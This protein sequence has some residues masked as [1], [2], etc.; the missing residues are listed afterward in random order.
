MHLSSTRMKSHIPSIDVCREQVYKLCYCVGKVNHTDSC[1]LDKLLLN[2]FF[3]QI[4]QSLCLSTKENQDSLHLASTVVTRYYNL[5]YNYGFRF[6]YGAMTRKI[7]SQCPPKWQP[8][9][10]HVKIVVSSIAMHMRHVWCMHWLLRKKTAL[11]TSTSCDSCVPCIESTTL[12][13]LII[14]TH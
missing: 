6:F 8:E 7:S 3:R 9:A 11:Q 4:K 10:S 1:N 12:A 14:E 2:T 5:Q 13:P